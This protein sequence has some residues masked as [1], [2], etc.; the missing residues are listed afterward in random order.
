MNIPVYI[1]SAFS[2]DDQGGNKAGIVIG[3]P[4]LSDKQKLQIAA[5]MGFSETAF[6][7]ASEEADYKIEY[8][9]PEEEVPL[10]GH[11]TIA[12][13]V[14]LEGLG[15]ID[16]ADIMIETKSG[17]LEIKCEG[18]RFFMEQNVPTFFEEIDIGEMAPC[19]GI[20][21][22]DPDIPI[23]IVS[24]GLKDILAPVK[25]ERLLNELTPDLDRITEI[26]KKYDVVGAHLYAFNKGRIICRNFAPLV[27]I[28]EEAATG[29]SNCALAGFLYKRL[30]TRRDTFVFEQGYSLDSIS[31]ISVKIRGEGND[32]SKIFVGG[33][34]YFIEKVDLTL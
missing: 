22:I 13:F 32:I 11:A 34:G 15:K 26:S 10:C 19:F 24:T 23:Q 1:V 2:K 8:F 31:E 20:D 6:V 16:K 27:G 29:T 25:S 21:C 9:T 5:E 14:M 4:L 18:D 3:E 28:P 30:D 17:M 33:A 12:T 7:T